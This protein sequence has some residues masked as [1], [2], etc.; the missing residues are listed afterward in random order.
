MFIY[1]VNMNCVFTYTGHEYTVNMKFSLL[2]NLIGFRITKETYLRVF[3]ERF[4]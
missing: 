1:T 3:P 2:G 4:N